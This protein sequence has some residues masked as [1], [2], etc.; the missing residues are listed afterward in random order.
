MIVFYKSFV[1][2]FR[3]SFVLYHRLI[4]I[5]NNKFSISLLIIAGI[6]LTMCDDIDI[7]MAYFVIHINL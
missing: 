3:K 2:L 1:M 6:F 7:M 4:Y 5:R